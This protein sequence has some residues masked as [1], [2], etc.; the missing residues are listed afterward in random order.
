MNTHG[1]V[2][3]N[4]QA[5]REWCGLSSNDVILGVAPLF[6]ITGLIAHITAAL[7][8]RR[9]AGAV[10]PVRAV[11]GHRR[12]R[13]APADVHGRLDHGVHRADERPERRA[14]RLEVARQDLLG[15]RA[16]PADHRQAL[17]RR[18]SAST[19]TTS[20]GSPRPPRRRTACRC[21]AESPVDEASGAL[22][23]GVPIY[24]TVVQIVGDD[25]KE[26][27]RRR[28]RRDRDDRAAGGG[29]LLEQAGGDRRT[30][31]PAARCTPA[32]SATWTRRAGSTS[33]TA[34]RTR[35]TRA[36]TR[37]GR[38]RSRTCSTSTRRCARPRWSACPTST[39]ARPSRR[40]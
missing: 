34:R 5:Y 35:S 27:P 33:S 40:S 19:S 24:N 18:R 8:P 11:V 25:G 32:T 1:N 10:P 6:H 2:V 29:G 20:T 31:S 4:G 15:R 12:H 39:A 30:R 17:L 23:V 21:G 3:F 16:D 37:S 14:G 26:L 28:G 13:G 36:A 7:L 22:S 38:A 9:A